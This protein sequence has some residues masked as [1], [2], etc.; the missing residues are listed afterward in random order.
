MNTVIED[1]REILGEIKQYVSE[2]CCGTTMDKSDAGEAVD[3]AFE[4]VAA[5]QEKVDALPLAL[6]PNVFLMKYEKA[7]DRMWHTNCPKNN[8]YNS[9]M[10][11]HDKHKVKRDGTS[12]T[13]W[14]CSLCSQMRWYGVSSG[15]VV[16]IEEL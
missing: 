13:V 11:Q 10:M 8:F 7:K 4:K 3:R 12:M 6:K 2:Q 14:R 1:L 15:H 16:H 9:E 5:L